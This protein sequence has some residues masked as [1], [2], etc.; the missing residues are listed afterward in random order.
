MLNPVK[1]LFLALAATFLAAI[2]LTSAG[3]TR[4]GPSIPATPDGTVMTVCTALGDSQPEYLWAALPA[5]YQKEIED[6]VVRAF[7][8]KLD[9]DVYGKGTAVLKKLSGVLVSKK[10]IIIN[11]VIGQLGATPMV[12]VDKPAL[13]R[14]WDAVVGLLDGLLA[15]E[16]G[17]LGRLKTI[18]VGSF[19]GTTGG[20]VMQKFAA[21][22]AATKE[23]PFAKEFKAKLSAMK[24]AVVSS[25]GDNAVLKITTTGEPEETVEF[26]KVEGKWLP[27]DLQAEW[28]E[29]IAEVKAR[30]AAFD[31]NAMAASKPKILGALAAADA[32]L[33]QLAAAKTPE[34]FGQVI[35]N[36][37][38]SLP[39]S[40][41]F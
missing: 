28:A 11:L 6:N 26:V 36:L 9:P 13:E 39:F 17:D 35:G 29:G 5:S 30:V 33:D 34:E 4:A 32:A 14:N 12:Q 40:P 41:E 23:D 10:E 18:D 3:C 22:S 8:A 19:L 38:Q 15:S 16:L 25:E 31:A 2:V 37:M 21:L 7:A 20:K 24:V 1:R 27:K